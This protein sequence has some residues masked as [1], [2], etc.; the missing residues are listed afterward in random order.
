MNTT[1]QKSK[2]PSFCQTFVKWLARMVLKEDMER[3]RS[4]SVSMK[5]NLDSL[6]S[7]GVRVW[8]EYGH[9]TGPGDVSI[10]RD[11]LEWSDLQ[12]AL[13][14]VKAVEPLTKSVPVA[15]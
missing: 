9:T 1:V 12:E 3:L 7:A 8:R 15:K 10:P 14:A 11:E 13:N 4:N 2:W 5:L 6:W